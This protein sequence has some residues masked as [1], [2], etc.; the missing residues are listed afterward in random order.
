MHTLPMT[1]ELEPACLALLRRHAESSLFLLGNLALH[2]P[3]LTESL[4][5]GNY[6]CL[7]DDAGAVRAVFC[8]TR[9]G[10]LLAQTDR[11]EDYSEAILAA[12]R[13]EPVA[14]AGLLAEWSIAE[15]LLAAAQHQTPPFAPDFTSNERLFRLPLAKAQSGPTPAVRQLA[16]ADFAEY[17]PLMQDFWRESGVPGQGTLESR[18][19]NF[20]ADAA[21]GRIWGAFADGRMVSTARLAAAVDG[22]GQVGAVYTVPEARRR[23]FSRQV[24]YATVNDGRAQG[25]ATLVLFTGDENVN[26]QALYRGVGYEEIGRFGLIFGS[27]K[28]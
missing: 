5:S 6:R 4:N 24:M 1:S 27:A 28:S 7:V 22:Y 26:A 25:L 17:E 9:R 8:L 10:N 19:A 2:G 20:A 16:A 21:L 14:I 12:C 18:R 11:M 23:G 3:A 13:Q 15:P